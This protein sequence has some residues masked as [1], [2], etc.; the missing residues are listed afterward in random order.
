MSSTE[1]TARITTTHRGLDIFRFCARTGE[2]VGSMIYSE[3]D[4]MYGV[5][6]TAGHTARTEDRDAACRMMVLG[7]AQS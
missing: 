1:T 6:D 5:M 4:G 2:C 3:W 7:V